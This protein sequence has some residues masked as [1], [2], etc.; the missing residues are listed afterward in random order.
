MR[1]LVTFEGKSSFEG[2][3]T[4]ASLGHP[5]LNGLAVERYVLAPPKTPDN[6]VQVLSDAFAKAKSDPE[7]I[8]ATDKAKEEIAYLD[9]D[10]AK[11]QASKS[12]EIY[13]KHKKLMSRPKS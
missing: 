12:I 10:A 5:E 8:A 4:I 6:I 11:S 1:G 2:V 7:L 9:A 3:P 13:E